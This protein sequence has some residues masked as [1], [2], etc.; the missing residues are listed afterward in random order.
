VARRYR[1]ASGSGG[2]FPYSEDQV[3]RMEKFEEDEEIAKK[4]LKSSFSLT[5][6]GRIHNKVNDRNKDKSDNPRKQKSTD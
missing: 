2:I 5:L 1:L 6:S 3:L 4:N